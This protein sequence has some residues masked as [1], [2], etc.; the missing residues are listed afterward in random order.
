MR[1]SITQAAVILTLL[2]HAVSSKGVDRATTMHKGQI[3]E[4]ARVMR[5]AVRDDLKKSLMVNHNKLA[6]KTKM[7]VS[8]TLEYVDKTFENF[9]T[10]FEGN[11]LNKTE[12]TNINFVALEKHTKKAMF[13]I[14]KTLMQNLQ[15]INKNSKQERDDIISWTHQRATL[16]EDILKTKISACV[17]NDNHFGKGVVNYNDGEGHFIQDSVSVRIKNETC[18]RGACMEPARKENIINPATGVFTVPR[19]AAGE[20][21]LT[22]T[23]RIDTWTARGRYLMKPSSYVFRKNHRKIKGTSI[24]TNVSPNWKSDKVPVSRT[25]FL[26]LQEG[27]EIDIF[28]EIYT[29]TLDHDVSFCVALLHLHEAS[30]NP[31]GEFS[32]SLSKKFPRATLANQDTWQYDSLVFARSEDVSFTN[33]EKDKKDTL[34]GHGE[35]MKKTMIST[36]GCWPEPRPCKG[37]DWPVHGQEAITGINTSLEE[38]EIDM[39]PE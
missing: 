24:S 19:Q 15:N 2:L 34:M 12:N 11:I 1:F 29:H 4:L 38:L 35:I 32:D 22:F 36:E 9:K 18:D 13:E 8:K 20:Y 7:F 10:H 3:E 28:Q 30:T 14:N 23:A 21:L 5:E 33:Q 39:I 31:G 16:N 27:D 17:K 37:S 6:E 25:I 26:K